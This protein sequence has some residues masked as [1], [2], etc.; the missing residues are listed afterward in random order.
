MDVLSLGFGDVDSSAVDIAAITRAVNA[1]PLPMVNR[2]AAI[3]LGNGLSAAVRAEMAGRDLPG[4]TTRKNVTA[5]LLAYGRIPTDLAPFVGDPIALRRD[6]IAGFVSLNSVKQGHDDFAVIG[7]KL[8]SDLASN[9]AGLPGDFY[10]GAS[11]VAS[12]LGGGIGLGLGV[13]LLIGVVVLRG[14]R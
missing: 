10:Q 8:L 4:P 6:V 9:I 2:D 14:R 3:L 11:D 1:V 12:K 13:A 5:K 7:G